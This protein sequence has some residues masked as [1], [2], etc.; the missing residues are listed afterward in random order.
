V[1]STVGCGDHGGD[2]DC[3][4]SYD[5]AQTSAKQQRRLTLSTSPPREPSNQPWSLQCC[6][7]LSEPCVSTNRTG[8]MGATAPPDP[9]PPVAGSALQ[10]PCSRS[11]QSP[12][13]STP[14]SSLLRLH[15]LAERHRDWG[16]GRA[17]HPVSRHTPQ[18]ITTH[19]QVYAPASLQ[20]HTAITS[21]HKYKCTV[22]FAY[23]PPPEPTASGDS[24]CPEAFG[25]LPPVCPHGADSQRP[26][27]PPPPHTHPIVNPLGHPL[28]LALIRPPWSA[29]HAP[30]GC[31]PACRSSGASREGSGAAA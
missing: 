13:H 2:S 23:I 18:S 31:A 20:T 5:P 1:G 12:P 10:S 16:T 22:L 19:K 9:A 30:R 11:P 7:A 27:H 17:P 3:C 15:K 25:H 21:L 29:P 26:P 8:H 24:P 14:V 28:G 6:R 4:V